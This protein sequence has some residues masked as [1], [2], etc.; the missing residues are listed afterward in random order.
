[1]RFW[2]GAGQDIRVLEDSLHDGVPLHDGM[3]P[4]HC[5]GSLVDHL[6]GHV[7][8]DEALVEAL[9]IMQHMSVY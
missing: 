5:H 4:A 8:E 3:H 7:H 2:H 9:G 1:M 6:F